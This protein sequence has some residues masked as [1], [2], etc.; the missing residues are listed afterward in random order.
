MLHFTNFY[1]T[2]F[3]FTNFHS[4]TERERALLSSS[5]CLEAKLKG[6][7]SIKSYGKQCRY[8]VQQHDLVEFAKFHV[9][10]C[11]SSKMVKSVAH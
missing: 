1:F 9:I 11:N 2:N 8:R 3:H 5:D 10:F 7:M 4:F 6:E